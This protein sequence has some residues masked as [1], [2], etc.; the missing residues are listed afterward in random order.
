MDTWLAGE[1]S[2]SQLIP[3]SEGAAS[4]IVSS[5]HSMERVESMDKLREPISKSLCKNSS[6]NSLEEPLHYRN[7]FTG[8]N[9]D[10]QGLARA[11]P[12]QRLMISAL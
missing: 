9:Q 4:P 5:V 2:A 7:T 1:S 11:A 6:Q 10:L 8:S 12:G 3:G